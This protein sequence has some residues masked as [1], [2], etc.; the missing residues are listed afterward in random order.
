MPVPPQLGLCHFA[1]PTKTQKGVFT[2]PVC[3]FALLRFAVC[4]EV[5]LA[6]KA[7]AEVGWQSGGLAGTGWEAKQNEQVRC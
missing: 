1:F 7:D 6:Q 4:T 5:K 2:D 3:L